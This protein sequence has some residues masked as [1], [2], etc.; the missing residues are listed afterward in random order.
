[1]K[2]SG[3]K[4]MNVIAS[5]AIIITNPFAVFSH[6]LPSQT[7]TAHALFATTDL[8]LSL[9]FEIVAISYQILN[10]AQVSDR[11][12]IIKLSGRRCKK[13]PENCLFSELLQIRP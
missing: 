5:K 9:F 8:T 13:H 10:G 11:D 4:K 2:I 1:M 6:T 3:L 12:K 7:K